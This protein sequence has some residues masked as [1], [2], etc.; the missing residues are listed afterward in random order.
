MKR[1]KNMIYKASDEARELFYMLLTQAFC[2]IARL[3]RVSK[4]SEKSKKG[5]L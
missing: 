4:T 2:M 1:T 5:D 3:S